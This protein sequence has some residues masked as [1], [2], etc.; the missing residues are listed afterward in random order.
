MDNIKLK[1]LKFYGYHGVLKPEKEIGQKF[2]VDVLL[3][4]DLQEPAQYDTLKDTVNY[5][6]AYQI[7]EKIFKDHKFDLIERVA[8]KII[9]DLFG[10]FEQVQAI[11]V[12]VKKPE[13]PV[14]GIYD[15][16]SVNLRRTRND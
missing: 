6:K 8:G 4:L 13:A 1:G 3:Y 15:Y 2:E 11:E 12:E 10:A 16:F 5:A 14:E 7:I 9:E